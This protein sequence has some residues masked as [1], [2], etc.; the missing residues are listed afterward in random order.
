M[1]RDTSRRAEAGRLRA[2]DQ[3]VSEASGGSDPSAMAART[4]SSLAA[5]WSACDMLWLLSSRNTT[6]R[7]RSP[8][9]WPTNTGRIRSTS[10]T[11][12][13]DARKSDIATRRQV[14]VPGSSRKYK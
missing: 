11:A 6:P 10:S 1:A 7:E 3:S 4:C 14:L 13:A 2:F 9:Y 12:N 5:R 8:R